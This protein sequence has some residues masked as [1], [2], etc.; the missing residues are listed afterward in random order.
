M[1]YRRKAHGDRNVDEQGPTQVIVRCIV[2]GEPKQS[3]LTA[4]LRPNELLA[5]CAE[6]A[7][8]ALR[9]LR[10]TNADFADCLISLSA[11]LAGCTRTMS[12]H[13]GAA[14]SAG[15]TLT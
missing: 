9:R 4:L 10:V 3:P 1:F 5:D 13:R 7:W 2:Q 14:Q 12:F 8:R 11:S 15:M 6:I